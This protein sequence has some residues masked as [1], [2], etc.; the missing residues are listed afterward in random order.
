[1]TSLEQYRA[2][3]QQALQAKD[4]MLASRIAA[5]AEAA[6]HKDPKLLVLAV[7]HHLKAGAFDRAQAA[8]GLAVELAPNSADALGAQGFC[9]IT[10]NKF[11]D[12]VAL[13]DRALRLQPRSA[14]LLYNKG[15]ALE[16]LSELAAARREYARALAIDPRHVDALGNG[17]YLAALQ[18]DMGEARELGGRALAINPANSQ[19]AFALS[20]AEIDA[21]KPQ[22]VEKR[23]RPFA[24]NAR[25]DR[26]TR[27]TA[28]GIMADAFDAL[29]D[30]ER[31]FASYTA[32]GNLK[33]DHFAPPPVYQFETQLA[34]VQRLNRYFATA[35][36][37]A[38]REDAA[39]SPVATHVFLLGFARTGTTLLEQVL[40][41]HGRIEAMDEHD[42]LENSYP[43]TD[44]DTALDRLAA[45]H[46][47]DLEPYRK[48]YWK[49]AREAG[50]TLDGKVFVDKM[51]MNSVVLCLIAKLF[52]NAKIVFA[53]RDPR[54]VVFSSFRRRFGITQQMFELLTL[55]S[56]AVYYDAVMTLVQTYR[57]VLDLEVRDLRYEDLLADFDGTLAALC[58]F[59]GVEYD[60]AMRDFAAKA[61]ERDVTTP[62][63]S[64][65]VRELNAGGAGQWRPYA[66][67]MAPVMPLLAPWVERFGYGA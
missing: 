12:A 10:A 47:G 6:G 28:H 56:A 33:R 34:R 11:K 15:F 42:C 48:D 59:L 21:G 8:A 65:V 38:W 3:A 29:G 49:R 63:A 53:L 32:K 44:T 55:E 64:Q 37:A 26:P 23:L 9:M 41:S 66:A 54:D 30:V 40:A 14:P 36:R 62:S 18:G 7:H 17:A 51:P 61:R 25:L 43:F 19:A 13:F 39:P 31:A 57:R 1:M 50:M 2:A 4:L 52:P 5:D 22:N 46:G 45:L 27:S 60:A 58:A 20:L 67:Q 16:C 35:D 24:E